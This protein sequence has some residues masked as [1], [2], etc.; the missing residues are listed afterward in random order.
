MPRC[1]IFPARLA[2]Y[3]TGLHAGR[4]AACWLLSVSI[5]FPAYAHAGQEK[6]VEL[7][8][9]ALGKATTEEENEPPVELELAWLDGFQEGIEA[10]VDNTARWFDGFFGDSRSFD[11]RYQ[12]QGRLTIGP[13]WSQ[14][15]GWRVRS[16]FRAEFALPNTEER[17]SAII[18]RT[19]FDDYAGGDD[20]HRRGS[21]LSS[22][23]GDREWILGLGFNPNQGETNRFSISAGIRKGLKAD[24]YSHAQYLYQYRIDDSNQI[25]S[26]SSL[27]WRDSDGFGVNQRLDLESS[28]NPEWLS[29]FSIDATRA[30]RISGIRWHSSYALYHVYTEQRA[31]A[32]E[33][34]YEGESKREVPLNDWGLRAIH[35]RN[36]ARDWLFIE[37]WGGLHWPRNELSERREARWILG[38]EFEMWYGG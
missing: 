14:Y 18:G 34:W 7:P 3:P 27:F 1:Q 30:E 10:S 13:E 11:D 5:L 2:V 24:L 28:P 20:S 32:G 37:M 31:I 36:F 16:S 21:V 15:D 33:V 9:E 6:P 29:R 22:A 25:R 8:I 26:R 38:L 17:F 23:R 4:A 12:S 35:R 19:S